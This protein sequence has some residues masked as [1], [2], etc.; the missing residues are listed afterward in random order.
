ML[1]DKFSNF[2]I[3]SSLYFVLSLTGATLN[4][5]L[6]IFLARILSVRDFGDFVA[7]VAISNQV[8]GFLLA[9]NLTSIYLVKNNPANAKYIVQVI[10]KVL[11]WFF[12]GLT[13]AIGL[14]WNHIAGWLKIEDPASFVILV[15][16]LLA[17]VPSVIW[18]GYLQGY[19][20]LLDIGVY[21]FSSSAFKFLFSVA[22]AA[23]GGVIGGLVGV[24][25]GTTLGLITL[26][27]ISRINLPALGT[28]F[29]RLTPVER[30]TVRG[31]RSYILGSI[32]I[33]GLLSM[34]QNIDIIYAK[35]MFD[36]E[37]AGIYS[38]LGVISY[39]IYYVGLALVWIVLSEISVDNPSHNRR[40]LTNSYKIFASMAVVATIFV[41]AFKD[42]IVGLLL[43]ENFVLQS[44]ILI[45]TLL[46]Q[47]SLISVTLYVFY[48]FVLRSVRA[49]LIGVSVITPA[50]LLPWIFGDNPKKM[51]LSLWCSTLLGVFVYLIINTV[52]RYKRVYE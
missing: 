14:L 33:V 48:L 17:A 18:T 49:P 20:K 37:V 12:L 24:F 42:Q 3:K 15:L 43:G 10:Q 6:Y 47:V 28:V 50:L 38:G 9:L 46:Y 4:Y 40:L 45:Y 34:M 5:L 39:L 36:P 31:L 16:I 8:I 23:A 11:I 22:L 2:Y 41:I 19:R 13:V 51:I 25:L 32:I 29:T 1:S 35:I 27:L 21:N 52:L 7:I 44:N 30:K 26:K